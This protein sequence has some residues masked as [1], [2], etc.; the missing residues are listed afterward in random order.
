MKNEHVQNLKVPVPRGLRLQIYEELLQTMREGEPLPSVGVDYQLCLSLPI[1]LWRLPCI[2]AKAPDGA[3]WGLDQ[4][5]TAFPEFKRE[6]IAEI[7][8]A[9]NRNEIRVEFLTE[10]IG[11]LKNQ[12]A[13]L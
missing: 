13:E 9:T 8:C 12:I 11:H 6:H 5:L 3:S 2:S 7:E 10:W 1:V 4:T